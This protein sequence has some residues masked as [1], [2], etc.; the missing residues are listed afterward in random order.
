M[1]TSFNDKKSVKAPTAKDEKS[2]SEETLYSEK[3]IVFL[4]VLGYSEFVGKGKAEDILTFVNFLT[5]CFNEI[6]VGPE[7]DYKGKITLFSDT[8]VLSF[9]IGKNLQQVLCSIIS[10]IGVVVY[11][12][13]EKFKL[14]LRGVITSGKIFHGNNLFGPGIIE[15]YKQEKDEILFPRVL[16]DKDKFSGIDFDKVYKTEND[17]I[18]IDYIS[19]HIASKPD[20][21][22]EIFEV[23]KNLIEAGLKNKEASIVAKYVWLK[24]YHNWAAEK[25]F[26]NYDDK[27]GLLIVHAATDT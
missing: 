11:R 20:E 16:I 19:A 4:D 9:E 23:H 12:I 5:K 2:K 1:S 8:I 15:A 21:K 13:F 26:D 7:R 6:I 14:P 27:K 17:T 24:D 3:I 10:S 22:N 25:H 18:S